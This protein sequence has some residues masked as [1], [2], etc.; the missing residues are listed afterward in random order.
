MEAILRG[1]LMKTSKGYGN[2][3][4]LVTMMIVLAVAGNYLDM[5]IIEWFK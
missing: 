3:V 5:Q 2:T 1:V 4:L